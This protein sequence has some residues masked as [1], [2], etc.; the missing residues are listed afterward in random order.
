MQATK[1]R[2]KFELWKNRKGYIKSKIHLTLSNTIEI[3]LTTMSSKG[4]IVIPPKFRE[5]MKEDL[6]LAKRTKA[7]WERYERGQFKA[8]TAKDFLKDLE[9][10]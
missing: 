8:S 4:Q 6:T 10:G 5:D 3:A 1:L 7:A 2:D 9:K